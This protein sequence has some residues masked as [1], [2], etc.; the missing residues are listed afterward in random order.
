MS[1]EFLYGYET[2]KPLLKALGI[3]IDAKAFALQHITL[4]LPHDHY[5]TLIIRCAP[6]SVLFED[7]EVLKALEASNVIVHK[8]Q[9][10]GV[11]YETAELIARRE[12]AHKMGVR[13][14]HWKGQLILGTD[15]PAQF[16]APDIRAIVREELEN[17]FSRVKDRKQ[18]RKLTLVDEY[19]ARPVREAFDT[20]ELE[21]GVSAKVTEDEIEPTHDEWGQSMEDHDE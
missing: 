4:E 7:E 8:I 15:S 21:G 10:G 6:T 18:A 12:I 19:K 20:E 17:V 3:D 5:P 13:S 11:P 16:T 14:F 9:G 2:M 1:D